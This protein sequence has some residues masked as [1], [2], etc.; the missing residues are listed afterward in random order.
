MNLR[1]DL[2]PPCQEDHLKVCKRGVGSRDLV[3]QL[4]HL[5]VQGNYVWIYRLQ[6]VSPQL[7][8]CESISTLRSVGDPGP[9]A[10]P[11]LPLCLARLEA[12]L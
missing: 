10:R 2:C 1:H 5:L 9:P 12:R 7:L 6:P 4:R 3:S 11:A 8:H